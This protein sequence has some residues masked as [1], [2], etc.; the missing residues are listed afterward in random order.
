MANPF[1]RA[2]SSRIGKLAV[3]PHRG[4]IPAGTCKDDST[5][6]IDKKTHQLWR[7]K[8]PTKRKTDLPHVRQKADR[9]P[10]R[11]RFGNLLD[12]RAQTELRQFYG[13]LESSKNCTTVL[14]GHM[15]VRD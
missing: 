8:M 7:E 14:V 10:M 5:R 15:P 13:A 3:A 11:Y 6:P 12:A 9:A 4:I 2:D 1:L